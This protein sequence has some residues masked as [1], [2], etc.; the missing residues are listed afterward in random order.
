MADIRAGRP[1]KRVRLGTAGE[2]ARQRRA[3][4]RT[5]AARER[6]R[7]ALEYFVKGFSYDE[8]ADELDVAYS[9]AWNLVQ[10]GLKLRAEQDG[11]IA[12]KARALLQMQIEALMTTWMPRALGRARTADG[13]MIPPDPRAADIMDKYIRRYA[14]I[15]GA[16]APVR[17]EGDMTM[18]P[19]DPASAIDT[20]M[21][22]LERT[23]Q[24]DR[25]VEGHLADVGHTQHE[26]MSGQGGDD[27]LPPPFPTEDAA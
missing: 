17:V 9:T 12:A 10:R 7:Q 2:T 16:M 13:E 19:A 22:M 8:I 6:E 24:K 20:I 4:M 21:A 23:A 18:Y 27:A 11:E 26:L 5:Q 3:R 15:T 14:E 25:V 1:P